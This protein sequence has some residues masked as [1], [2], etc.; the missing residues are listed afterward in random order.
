M[1]V[2]VTTTGGSLTLNAGDNATIDANLSAATTVTINID[3]D[4]D[5]GAT[6]FI[7][8]TLPTPVVITRRAGR[9]HRRRAGRYVRLRAASRDADHGPG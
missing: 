8:A 2:Q 3:E 4:T 6:L 9:L 1:N 7:D 5:A